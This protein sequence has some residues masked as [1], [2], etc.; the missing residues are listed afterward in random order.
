MRGQSPSRLSSKRNISSRK[1]AANSLFHRILPVSLFDPRFCGHKDGSP[2]RN[3]PDFN[4]L[5]AAIRKKDFVRVLS[6]TDPCS[7]T[8]ADPTRSRSPIKERVRPSKQS[9]NSLFQKILPVTPFD[10]RFC[11]HKIAS[12]ARNSNEC[13]ILREVIRKIFSRRS[14][15]PDHLPSSPHLQL[16]AAPAPSPSPRPEHFFH[17]ASSSRRSCRSSPT[18]PSQCC[19]VR[20]T[21]GR[22]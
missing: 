15:N 11:G 2:T 20:A 5:R 17:S 8:N 16:T 22:L 12:T 7:L 18:W 14:Q 21:C 19:G 1:S 6:A 9:S 13:N 3:S 4:I 10:P